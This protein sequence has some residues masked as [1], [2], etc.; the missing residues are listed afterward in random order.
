MSLTEGF[1]RIVLALVIGIGGVILVRLWIDK[2]VT[3]LN[4]W[5]YKSIY[6]DPIRGPKARRR[7]ESSALAGKT[8]LSAMMI[9]WGLYFLFR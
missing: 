5:F 3:P 1:T 9:L 6:Q 7:V 8:L 2:F 4:N